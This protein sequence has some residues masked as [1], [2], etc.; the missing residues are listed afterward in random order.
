MGTQLPPPI[1]GDSSPPLFG[2]CIVAK[3][4]DQDATWYRGRPHPRPHCVRW[5]TQLP[6]K[7]GHSPPMSVVAKR[8]DY[9]DAT[10]YKSRRQ[11]R[12][13]CIRWGPSSPCPQ[14]G[15]SPQ[16]FG[17]CL[18][19]PNGLPSQLLLSTCYILSTITDYTGHDETFFAG[20]RN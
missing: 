7:K 4:L 19:W 12:R 5:E 10:W 14:K 18:L 17:P 16:I 11:P 2:P 3:R 15:H 13:H 20:P 8:L 1:K 6:P 9:Q